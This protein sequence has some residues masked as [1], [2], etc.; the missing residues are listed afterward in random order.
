MGYEM[1]RAYNTHGRNEKREQYTVTTPERRNCAVREAPRRRQLLDDGSLDTFPHQRIGLWKPERCYEINTRSYGDVD[2]WKPTRHRTLSRV[3]GQV[4][5][6][7]HGYRK[8]YKRPCREKM[9][10]F[11]IRHW[12]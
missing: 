9:E 2:S 10:G 3:N 7:L 12:S 8:L 5:N 6:A 4:T 11:F 1:A